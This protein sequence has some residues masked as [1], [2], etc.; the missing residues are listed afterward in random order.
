MYREMNPNKYLIL[1]L[2]SFCCIG[3]KHDTH[4]KHKTASEVLADIASKNRPEQAKNILMTFNYENKE[5]SNIILEVARAMDIKIAV[6]EDIKIVEKVTVKLGQINL[7]QAWNY[8]QTMLEQFGY[9][10]FRK[11]AST[12]SLSSTKTVNTEPLPIYV[13]LSPSELPSIEDRIRY[14]YYFKNINIAPGPA[15]SNLESIFNNLLS[16]DPQRNNFVFDQ[17]SNSVLI[18]NK[19]TNIKSVMNIVS[20]LDKTGFRETI[21]VIPLYHAN[22]GMVSDILNKLIPG[23]EAD[24][25]FGPQPTQPKFGYY[26]SENTKI[27][28][29][30]KTNSVV[31]LGNT[32]SVDRVRDFIVKYL[33][34]PLESGSSVIHVKE[35]QY[36][37]AKETKDLLSTI[38][39]ADTGKVQSIVQQQLKDTLSKVIIA[40]EIEQSA[41]AT[42]NQTV[43]LG[44]DQTISIPPPVTGGNSLIIAAQTE[45]WLILDKLIDELDVPQIQVALEALIV[46][47]TIKNDKLLGGQSRNIT[48]GIEREFNWQSANLIKPW[49]NFIPP[50]TGTTINTVRGIAADLLEMATASSIGLPGDNIINL[51]TQAVPGSTII[52]FNDGNGISNVLQVLDKYGNTTILSQPFVITK[53]HQI[54]KIT[55]SESRLVDGAVKQ[56]S[57]GGPVI[58]TRDNI[59]ADLTVQL[60]PRVSN[61]NNINLEIVVSV[62]DF[63]SSDNNTITNRTVVT[64]ANI[65]NKEVLVLG[66]LTK[67]TTTDGEFATP[68]LSRIPIFGYFFKQRSRSVT[69]NSLMIFIQPTIIKPRIGGGVDPYTKGKLEYAKA[70]ECQFEEQIEGANFENL[71]DPI[72]R[73]FFS[74]NAIKSNDDIDEYENT[75]VFGKKCYDTDYDNCDP[76]LCSCRET[77]RQAEQL[78]EMMKNQDNPLINN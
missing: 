63:V 75:G 36:L 25:R 27:T 35:L 23:K 52:S 61:T 34:K 1:C 48:A 4:E 57:T 76:R 17:N 43:S 54:A 20:E 7:R 64:N 26:F 16:E 11:D 8:L 5:L 31:I 59:F 78:K 45:D 32:E 71:R 15:R 72:T 69:K 56:Q 73:V 50:G 55:V 21:L 40:A 2:I 39:K 67:T 12:Y 49:L 68:L 46:D 13:N 51:A 30:E 70:K 3:A 33:D 42:D 77:S 24:W 44:N 62:K 28:F 18:S 53:N 10:L 74:S 37:N 58:L 9:V 29:I 22:A 38:V 41:T 6:P 14:L 47:M 66:G 60:V 19:A 65:G